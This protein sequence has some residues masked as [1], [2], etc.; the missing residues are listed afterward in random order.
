MAGGLR[1]LGVGDRV[2]I[3]AK[4][5]NRWQEAGMVA[6][7]SRFNQGVPQVLP[8]TQDGIVL[9]KNTTG[10]HLPRFAVMGLRGSIYD[11][12]YEPQQLT[13]FKNQIALRGEVP[14]NVTLGRFCVL[15]NDATPGEIVAGMVNGLTPV[16]LNVI[17]AYDLYADIELD[18]AVD[19]TAYLR[20][21]GGGSAQLIYRP[22]YTGVQWGI[23][24]ISNMQRQWFLGVTQEDF[25]QGTDETVSVESWYWNRTPDR[26]DES[27]SGA[28]V[29]FDCYDWFLNEGET[30]EKGTKVKC[31]WYNDRWVITAAYC[32]PSDD[33]YVVASLPE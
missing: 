19:Q 15:Q 3:A 14:S 20:T 10:V 8:D 2:Q 12:L 17:S 31:E 32:S 24:R 13:E 1:K 18:T 28:G 25:E 22:D 26:W 16:K 7:L 23:V 30:I 4:D 9:V 5:Y 29:L 11:P 33:E 27:D 21:G 6:A